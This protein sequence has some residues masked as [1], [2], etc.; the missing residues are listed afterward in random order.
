VLFWEGWQGM[1]QTLLT[2]SI[3]ALVG[4]SG[5]AG[6]LSDPSMGV[7]VGSLSEPFL[8]GGSIMPV[9]GGGV[10][11]Y[12]NPFST[13]ITSLEFDVT[14]KTGLSPIDVSKAFVCNDAKTPGGNANPF[15]LN[16][17]VAYNLD[18]G[19]LLISFF[20]VNPPSESGAGGQEGIPPLL[21]GCG[22]TPD[23]PGCTVVGHFLITLNDNFSIQGDPSGGWSVARSPDLFTTDPVIRIDGVPE[24]SSGVLLFGG[25]AGLSFLAWKSARRS[26]RR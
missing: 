17:G 25:L 14:I 1:K 3:A 24:P 15:F 13:F 8:A 21:P 19:L 7:K 5:W 2:V 10:F 26:A 23:G 6:T 11:G 12:Y 9:N 16:C 4:G 20:G 22:H 18:S